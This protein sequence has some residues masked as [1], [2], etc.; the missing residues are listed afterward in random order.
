[1]LAVRCKKL[2]VQASYVHRVFEF[3]RKRYSMAESVNVLCFIADE[4][5]AKAKA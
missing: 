5:S 4:Y 1:M 3:R 2:C